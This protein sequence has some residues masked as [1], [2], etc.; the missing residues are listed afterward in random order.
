MV[1]VIINLMVGVI[2]NHYEFNKTWRRRF[3]KHR[4]VPAGLRFAYEFQ[5]QIVCVYTV[6]SIFHIIVNYCCVIQGMYI[7]YDIHILYY[8]I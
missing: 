1:D 8:Y 7:S 6:Q 5:E 3:I 2:I 4:R